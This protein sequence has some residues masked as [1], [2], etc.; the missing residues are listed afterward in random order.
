[1]RVRVL[2]AE[3]EP[4]LRRALCA[5][6]GRE[7]TFEVVAEAADA[8]EAIS[9]ASEHH[10]DVAILDVKM[11]GGG[12]PRA[13]REIRRCSP[14]TRMI[15]YSAYE[16]R[17][18]VLQMV[19]AGAVGYLV[20]GTAPRALIDGI[21]AVMRGQGTLSPEVAPEVL[22]EL[23]S[24]LE[25]EGTEREAR[26]RHERRIRAALE[27]PSILQMVFQPV[28]HLKSREVA[29]YEA[30]S[31]FHAEPLRPPN[32][33]FAEAAGVDLL[34]DLELS[35]IRK[36]LDAARS[37]PEPMMLGVNTSP[38]TIIDPRFAEVIENE[39]LLN[40]VFEI[41]E[42]APVE[43]YET[44]ELALQGVRDRGG[45]LAVDD[46]GA[47]FASLRHI[48]RLNPE[49]IKID[50]SLTQGVHNDPQRRALAI[51]LISFA[52]EM[53]AAVVAEGIEDLDDLAAFTALGVQYG[54]GYYFG[55]P[56]PLPDF[57]PTRPV[58]RLG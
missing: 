23:A 19:R 43:D 45:Q 5:L 8:D 13:A 35:A 7:E 25:T 56:G 20:K 30:L 12:G 49:L 10:P 28:V 41:T 37:L 57:A 16:D 51:A 1:M 39:D 44:I 53:G 26:S 27:N 24:M 50:V 3:D 29:G 52:R 9:L 46:A 54:Q 17:T 18:T 40:I 58:E 21:N 33:W 22:G 6:L 15:A 38:Q 48:L 14:E 55:K 47:G 4:L 36:G 32:V 31:R 11:L 2:V 34:T 42:H